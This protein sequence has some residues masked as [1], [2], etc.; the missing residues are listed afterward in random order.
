MMKEIYCES[1][2]AD[3]DGKPV[4][5]MPMRD[6]GEIGN[7]ER[8]IELLILYQCDKCKRIELV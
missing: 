1:C 6:V 5:C 4:P 2:C 7:M 3:E 8:G